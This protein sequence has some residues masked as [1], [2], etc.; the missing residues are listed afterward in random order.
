MFGKSGTGKSTLLDLLAFLAPPTACDVFRLTVDGESHDLRAAWAGRRRPAIARLR[1]RYMG[2]VLQTGGLIPYL[3]LRDN[4]LLS[5]RLLGL[6]GTGPVDG[7]VRRLELCD[8]ADRKPDQVSIGQRQRAA[9]VRAL[10]HEPR[11]ILTDEPT[12]ALDPDRAT[13]LVD[14]L[15][16]VTETLGTALILV[17]H[18]REIADRSGGRIVQC[19]LVDGPSPPTSV[20]EC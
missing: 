20:L 4:F 11:L 19:R 18:D 16:E 9:V 13:A 6:P 1:A 10:A 5:R 7:L 17:T 15:T 14:V 12:A 2:Y 3:S 8:L